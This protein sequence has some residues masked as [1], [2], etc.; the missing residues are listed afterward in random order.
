MAGY[1]NQP[2]TII[3]PSTQRTTGKDALSMNIAS[4]KAV[5]SIV[6]TTLGPKGM[7]KMMVN[8]LGDITLTN[9]GAT[10]L[11][12]MDIEHPTAKMIVEIAK[13]Q[14]KIA[15][16]GTT[17]AVVMAAAL[18]DKAQKLMETG[19]H[20]TIL[21]KG[22]TM[23]SQ[24]ALSVLNDYAIIVDKTD[25]EMLEKIANTSITGKASEMAGEQLAKIC[26]DAIYGIEYEGKVNVDED[27]VIAKEVGGTIHD[28]ELINGIAI[29]KEALNIEMPRRIENAKIILIDTDL[30]FA[31]TST[32]SKLHIDSAEQLADFKEKEKA[33]F[34]KQIQKIIDT[35]ANAV[36]CSKNI[37]DYAVHFFKKANMYATRRVRDEDMAVLSYS[38]GATLVRNVNEIKADDLGYAEL[39]E[40]ED[41]HEEKTYIK[42]FKEARTMTI[43]I[44]GGTEHV[45]DNIERVFDDA[46]HV[47]QAVYEDGKIVPG[48]GASEIKV[49]QALR[50][51]AASVEGREQLAIMAFA[52]AIEEIPGT[53]AE[54]C[55]FDVIDTLVNLR[56]KHGTVKNAGLDVE[57]GDVVDMLERGIVDPLRVKTQAIKSASESAIMVLRID[58]ML[59]A[60]E[61]AMMDVAPEHNI[62]N[63][64]M[65]G[66]M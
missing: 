25:S 64:D 37:D 35:G 30:T 29:A 59:R 44:K 51:Y 61:K 34:R 23:A 46:L 52:E 21:I 19:V 10:I 33:N 8:I 38:T 18:L 65:G 20:P 48:G 7:D 6:K 36:F 41:G 24:K 54:N 62:H 28:T 58:D 43:L 60:R 66:M 55:G 9:D 26:V 32:K 13:T 31:Q 4:A 42:G 53:I 27:I 40:Q 17:S 50:A 11:D 1:R 15:G 47:V 5:A 14:E 63:Y 56:S 12:E 49:A 16:D 45:T 39:I 57:T 22:Y 3:D 2:I